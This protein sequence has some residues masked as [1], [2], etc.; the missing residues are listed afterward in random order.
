[1]KQTAFK[2]TLGSQE[3]YELMSNPWTQFVSNPQDMSV[4][5][6][7]SKDRPT[8][9]QD[10]MNPARRLIITLVDVDVTEQGIIVHEPI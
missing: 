9:F 2:I 7:F 4:S 10:S 3:F 6:L 1:M 5:L 8:I